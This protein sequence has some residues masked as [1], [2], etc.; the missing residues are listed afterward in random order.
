MH[1]THRVLTRQSYILWMESM[2]HRIGDL[3]RSTEEATEEAET[4]RARCVLVE[5]ILRSEIDLAPPHRATGYDTYR[6]QL[7]FTLRQDW[8]ELPFE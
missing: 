4:L 1:Y 8:P 3:R 6:D 2:I 7:L 5:S